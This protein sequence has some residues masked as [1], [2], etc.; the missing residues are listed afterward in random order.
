MD[1]QL[2]TFVDLLGVEDALD[3]MLLAAA[4][5]AW[6]AETGAADALDLP[7]FVGLSDFNSTG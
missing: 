5:A 4:T 2:K 1:C 3:P 6:T 7:G